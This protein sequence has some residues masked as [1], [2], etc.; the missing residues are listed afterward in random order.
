MNEVLPGT[1]TKLIIAGLDPTPALEKLAGQHPDISLI[2]NP[3]DAA[4][5]DLIQNAQVNIMVTF[6]PTGLKLKVL[7]SLFSGRH[8]LVNPEMVS[9][10][11]LG[12]LCEIA[13]TTN[14]F[15]Q[16]LMDLM[17]V[18]FTEREIS[19]RSEQLLRVHSNIQNCKTLLDLLYLH[20]TRGNS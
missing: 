4:M 10:T 3:E 11:E 1:G 20:P 16:K 8:C 2:A 9:G 17:L 7:N 14:E 13:S 5:A 12:S 19:T 15:K 18:P 6:Q